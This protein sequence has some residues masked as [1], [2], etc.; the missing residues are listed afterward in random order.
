[1]CIYVHTTRIMYMY[2]HVHVVVCV[3]VAT[4]HVVVVWTR[5]GS[6]WFN[7]GVYGQASHAQR[8][9]KEDEEK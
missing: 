8:A 5:D 7:H 9:R 1:M 2:I 3:H 4:V 6:S